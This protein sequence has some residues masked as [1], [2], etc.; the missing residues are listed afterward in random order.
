MPFSIT[1]SLKSQ[2]PPIW[3]EV[4]FAGP[5]GGITLG[6]PGELKILPVM[7]EMLILIQRL[8]VGMLKVLRHHAHL[9]RGKD[10][11]FRV[12]SDKESPR[13]APSILIEA[14][15]LTTNRCLGILC[16]NQHELVKTLIW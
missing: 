11:P 16:V 13:I 4:T 2:L 14:V 6:S 3:A 7:K 9:Y 12:T 5:L 10:L 15:S 8:R 1:S